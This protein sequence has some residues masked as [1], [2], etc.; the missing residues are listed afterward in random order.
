MHVWVRTVANSGL[1]VWVRPVAHFGL[2]IFK[3]TVMLVHVSS[4]KTCL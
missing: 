4:K 2:Q 3:V 1:H